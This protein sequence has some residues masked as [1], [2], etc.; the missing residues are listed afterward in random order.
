MR[1]VDDMIG[2]LISTL[3]AKSELWKTVIIFTSDNGF[4]LG[5]HRLHGKVRVYEE[6]IRVPLY[7]R[8]PGVT[9]KTIDRLVINNDFAPTFLALAKAKADIPVDGRSLVPLIENPGIPWRNGL[10][11]WCGTGPTREAARPL[12]AEAMQN[13]YQLPF[14]R[15]EKWSPYGSAE[16]LAEF[17]APY[18]EAGCTEF[19]L[20]INGPDADTEI[21]TVAEVKKL[22]A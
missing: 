18:V 10:N 16:D 17:V 9:A 1:A 4:M 22:L 2:K 13:F 20:I 21:E 14:E 8:I 3:A 19:N 5:E 15:F 7:M 6:A 11:M 12:V